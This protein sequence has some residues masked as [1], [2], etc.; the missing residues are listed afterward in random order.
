[1]AEETVRLVDLVGKVIRGVP[2]AR[3][4][5]S[6]T[7]PVLSI[8]DLRSGRAPRSFVEPEDLQDLQDLGAMVAEPDDVLISIEGGTVGECLAVDDTR[9]TFVPSQQVATV[10]VDG[11]ALV[12]PWYLAAW[13][14]SEEGERAVKML[15]HGA[16]IQRIAIR[17]LESLQVKVLPLDEQRRIGKL[18]QAFQ[19][20]IQSHRDAIIDLE[21]LLPIEVNQA[22]R[23]GSTPSTSGTNTGVAEK[24]NGEYPSQR[25]RRKRRER[26]ASGE[27]GR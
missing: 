27:V 7:I 6:G 22:I 18:Y 8:A 13:L 24:V 19:R 21:M 1:M 2:T 16:A 26:D 23:H 17:D 15:A 10:R 14:G 20:S 11:D 12:D 25:L 5:D 9:A 4:L 3:T